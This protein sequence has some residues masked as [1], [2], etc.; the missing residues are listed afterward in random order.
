MIVVVSLL[1]AFLTLAFVL[2]PFF[3]SKS[4]PEN[5]GKPMSL[6]RTGSIEEDIEDQVMKMRNQRGNFCS[7]CGS[8]NRTDARFC[9]KCGVKLGKE[10]KGG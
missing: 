9:S 3:K 1:L 10:N 2:Y 7:H 4:V 8:R 6:G 5:T